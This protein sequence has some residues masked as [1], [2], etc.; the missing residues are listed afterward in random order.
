M[1]R[2]A[3]SAANRGPERRAYTTSQAMNQNIRYRQSVS[4]GWAEEGIVL[5]S[6][7]ERDTRQERWVSGACPHSLGTADVE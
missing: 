5:R 6:E 1:D 4:Q 2:I 3:C 7:T